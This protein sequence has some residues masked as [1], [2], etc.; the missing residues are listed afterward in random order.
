MHLHLSCLPC[1][2]DA[3]CSLDWDHQVMAGLHSSLVLVGLK[4]FVLLLCVAGTLW[5]KWWESWIEMLKYKSLC[6]PGNCPGAAS[7]AQP[8]VLPV[9]TTGWHCEWPAND[10][11][12]HK[13]PKWCEW[14]CCEP[15]GCSAC[16][17]GFLL[18][19]C[20]CLG[21]CPLFCVRMSL[22]N[23]LFFLTTGSHI[24]HQ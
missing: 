5:L 21:P 16:W 18:Q 3:K 4:H 6:C 22:C 17:R 12:L 9:H 2:S 24:K 23:G 1:S 8:V 19:Q 10:P 7:G 15:G 14:T 20:A 11:P 13:N